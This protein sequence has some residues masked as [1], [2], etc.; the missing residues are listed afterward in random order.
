VQ[1]ETK[2]SESLTE[3]E[4]WEFLWKELGTVRS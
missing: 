2:T 4:T 1:I 3:C